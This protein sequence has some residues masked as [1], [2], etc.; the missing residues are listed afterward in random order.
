MSEKVNE[1]FVLFFDGPNEVFIDRCLKRGQAGSGRV[2]DNLE[3][4]QKRLVTYEKD[5][6]PIIEHYRKQGLVNRIDACE[7]PETVFEKVKL[8]FD[9]VAKATNGTTS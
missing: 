5:T 4:L 1:Q 8:C 2:D 9:K 6:K 3:S 7:S